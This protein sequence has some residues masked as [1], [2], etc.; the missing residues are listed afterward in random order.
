VW[1]LGEGLAS[2]PVAL[3]ATLK[4][5]CRRRVCTFHQTSHVSLCVLPALPAA[6]PTVRPAGGSWAPCI[7][8]RWPVRCL[9]SRHVKERVVT[10][11]VVLL[12]P[13]ATYPAPET[14]PPPASVAEERR[15]MMADVG[16]HRSRSLCVAVKHS[17][18]LVVSMSIAPSICSGFMSAESPIFFASGAAGR[19][20]DDLE[21]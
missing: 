5:S 1:G 21:K 4:F 16:H 19:A 20:G 18:S 14:N 10:G 9:T 12:P 6:R 15:A 13:F 11:W 17:V 3:N 8:Q 7:G 2:A